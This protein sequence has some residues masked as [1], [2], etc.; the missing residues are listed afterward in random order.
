MAIAVNLVA[1][2]LVVGISWIG[3]MWMAGRAH[4]RG[5]PGG[6]LDLR[7]P[8]D[9]PF[10]GFDEF[11]VFA[12]DNAH[13]A[14]QA[15]QAAQGADAHDR[16]RARLV[17]EPCNECAGVGARQRLGRLEPCPVCDGTGVDRATF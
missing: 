10:D 11:D 13:P 1:L 16:W 6:D 2:L 9:D 15:G 4:G 14:A 7:S 17:D 12:D 8:A 5:A 3:M